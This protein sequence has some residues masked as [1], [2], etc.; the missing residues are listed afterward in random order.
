MK[1]QTTY[2]KD[3]LNRFSVSDAGKQA[4]GMYD[5]AY[6]HDNCGIGSVVT[7]RESRHTRLWRTR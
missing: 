7:S 1:E 4:A 2:K 3:A 5:P 6:E